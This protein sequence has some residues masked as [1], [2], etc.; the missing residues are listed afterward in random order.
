MG[1]D[2]KSSWPRSQQVWHESCMINAQIF[3]LSPVKIY[4]FIVKNIEA[5]YTHSFRSL[6]TR[7]GVR[8]QTLSLSLDDEVD[9]DR[10]I[11]LE[12]GDILDNR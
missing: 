12:G 5:R 11:N 2:L 3:S 9:I 8:P 6:V 4:K 1:R 7:R 10:G